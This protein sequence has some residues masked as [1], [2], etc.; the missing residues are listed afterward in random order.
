MDDHKQENT[1]HATVLQVCSWFPTIVLLIKKLNQV[2]PLQLT[3]QLT[4]QQLWLEYLPEIGTKMHQKM[5][6]KPASV[7]RYS[8]PVSKLKNL[9]LLII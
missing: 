9:S 8:K 3:V 1:D 5:Q 2:F 7:P 4:P 6:R